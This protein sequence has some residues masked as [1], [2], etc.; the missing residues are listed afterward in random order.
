[1]NVDPD[2]IGAGLAARRRALPGVH[3]HANSNDRVVREGGR[4]ESALRRRGRTD[5]RGRAIEDDEERIA[6][7]PYL[8]SGS[9]RGTEGLCM[10]RQDLVIAVSAELVEELRRPLDVRE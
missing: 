4:G 1:M 7:D 6:F 2:V 3:A 8:R 9:E 5:R 10:R